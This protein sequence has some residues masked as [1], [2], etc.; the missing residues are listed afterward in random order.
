M[1]HFGV[2]LR[3][4]YSTR[5]GGADKKDEKKRRKEQQ[6]EHE[7]TKSRLSLFF[8]AILGLGGVQF[9]FVIYQYFT[10]PYS[11]LS[12]ENIEQLKKKS[13]YWVDKFFE[14]ETLS[15]KERD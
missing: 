4:N 13:T 6:S 9:I 3:R 7:K 1:N 5:R 8:L 14:E 2:P 15:K 10:P 12:V 11:F